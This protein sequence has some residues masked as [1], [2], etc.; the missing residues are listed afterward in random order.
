MNSTGTYNAYS[1][2][3]IP[4]L[5]ANVQMRFSQDFPTGANSQYTWHQYGDWFH[6]HY[7]N[8]GRLIQYFYDQ[9]GSGYS[10]ALPVLHTYV[11][12]NI[13]ASAISK[14]GTSLYSISMVRT[15][16]SSNSN[17]YQIG[18]LQRGQMSMQ[19][20]DENGASV[21]NVWRVDSLD[22]AGGMDSM[23]SNG[24]MENGTNM[25]NGQSGTNNQ[26]GMNNQSGSNQSGS[27]MNNQQSGMYNG[28]STKPAKT[29]RNT[30]TGTNSNT[31]N[32][33]H[34]QHQ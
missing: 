28:K 24:A 6:T 15:A 12:E 31:N 2:T 5:P 3:A 10:L 18:L 1:G 14:Y 26:S 29:K 7:N 20:L 9:R 23:Q 21:A 4:S 11:P 8:N 13:I 32:Q 19:Y 22:N 27:N 33:D 17:A 16:D 25:N 34:N 30:N